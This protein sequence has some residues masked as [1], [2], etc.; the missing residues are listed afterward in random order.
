MDDN[1]NQ[2]HEIRAKDAIKKWS[3]KNWSIFTGWVLKFTSESGRIGRATK[4]CGECNDN[5][6]HITSMHWEPHGLY[7]ACMF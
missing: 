6:Y 3:P 1:R 7:W 5:F 4:I 2:L